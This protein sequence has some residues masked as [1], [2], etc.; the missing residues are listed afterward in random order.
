MAQQKENHNDDKIVVAMTGSTGVL[1]RHI[2]NTYPN[3]EYHCF[4]GC[5]KSKELL[6]YWV[7]SLPPVDFFLHLAAVVAVSEVEHDPGQ[8]W[9]VNVN[10][11]ENVASAVTRFAK[12][13][14]WFFLASTAHVYASSQTNVKEDA[15]CSPVST[16]GN[17]KLE[18]EQRFSDICRKAGVPFCIGRIFSYTSPMQGTNFVIP[19]LI[20]RM[21]RTGLNGSIVIPGSDNI[22]DFLCGDQ[23]G[24]TIINLGR[25]RA[26]GV[27]NVGSG[28]GTSIKQ[29]A[30]QIVESIGRPDIKLE[31][32]QHDASIIVANVETLTN[33]IDKQFAD[34]EKLIR[35]YLSQ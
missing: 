26:T 2:I 13:S 10:G 6:D 4:H 5:I 9:K 18:A 11:T 33:I 32:P 34:P 27:I 23:I 1:G 14:P 28:E 12:K 15:E 17:Q 16:Y 7:A 22:R 24:K 20:S 29:I 35:F 3:F 31:C 8:A 30:G 25:N 19:N 21:R